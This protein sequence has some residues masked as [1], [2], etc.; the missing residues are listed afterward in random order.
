L[1]VWFGLG[2]DPGAAMGA[3]GP[4]GDE[5]R[6]MTI[7]LVAAIVARAAAVAGL[8][9]LTDH[10]KVPFGSFFGDEEYFI[11]QSIWLRNTGL[12]LPMHGADL[13]HAFDE[14]SA[15]RWT[16]ISTRRP[17]FSSAR[18]SAT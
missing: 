9:A 18:S 1:T 17:G 10:T 12:G 3:S 14:Y 6:W 5:R 7:V 4:R 11:K 2:D 13:V 15:T 8:F 16:C